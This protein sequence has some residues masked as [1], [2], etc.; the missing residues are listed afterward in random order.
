MTCSDTAVRVRVLRVL[1]DGMALVD[2]GAGHEEVSVALVPADVVAPGAVLL[3]HAREAI[4]V[5]R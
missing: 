2:T 4:G 5:P 1:D 3:V